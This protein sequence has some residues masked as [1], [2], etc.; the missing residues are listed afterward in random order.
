MDCLICVQGAR[1]HFHS[2]EAMVQGA[3][4]TP[5]LSVLPN[6]A[7]NRSERRSHRRLFPHIRCVLQRCGVSQY[8]YDL[9]SLLS[10]CDR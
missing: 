9:I 7:G 5:S 2:A 1:K 10:E 8:V 6:L 4:D 3:Y